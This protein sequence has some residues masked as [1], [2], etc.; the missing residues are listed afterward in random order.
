MTTP[1][2]LH[3]DIP[4]PTMRCSYGGLK[5]TDKN[6]VTCKNCLYRMGLEKKS[7]GRPPKRS[8]EKHKATA[9]TLSPKASEIIEEVP[10]DKR[11][12]WVSSLIEATSRKK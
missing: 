4:D 10:K 1:P 7:F 6:K 11:S 3:Y 5:T 2:K 9:F 8:D 12:A